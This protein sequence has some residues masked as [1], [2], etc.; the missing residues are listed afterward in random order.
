[1]GGG[2]IAWREPGV[3]QDL[4]GGDPGG[5][6]QLQ[7]P[8]NEVLG[9]AWHALPV[10]WVDKYVVL[11]VEYLN[12][13]F[14][15]F[16]NRLLNLVHD[17]LSFG[18]SVNSSLLKWHRISFGPLTTS[19]NLSGLWHRRI[20]CIY[21]S[22]EILFSNEWCIQWLTHAG[23]IRVLIW[24]YYHISL[25]WKVDLKI[26]SQNTKKIAYDKIL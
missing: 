20:A 8:T 24:S 17:Y 11:L 18:F 5:R 14:R 6:L 10:A 7:H 9:V 26:K 22:Q 19:Y 12:S 15:C 13:Y 4:G 21:M 1:M 16:Y 3:G 25:T 2:L 23:Y